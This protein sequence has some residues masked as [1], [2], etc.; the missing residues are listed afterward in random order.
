M[1]LG[2][3]PKQYWTILL[4]QAISYWSMEGCVFNLNIIMQPICKRHF[5]MKPKLSRTLFLREID[6]QC[7]IGL[8]D[9]ER[10]KPQ[11][12]LIDV[13][14]RLDPSAEPT[15]DTVE[16]TLDYDAVHDRV[17]AIAT[18]QHYDLQET[19]A[20]HLFDAIRGMRDVTGLTVQTQKTEAYENCHSVA[21]RLSDLD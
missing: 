4:W 13:E 16:Q 1:V 8:H 15:S 14:I 19:L 11:T 12:V 10:Q 5:S 6:V 18:A 21:Y 17:V 2:Q 20:R 9:H 3:P 7:S